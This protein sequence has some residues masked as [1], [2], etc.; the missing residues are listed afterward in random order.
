M[1]STS[2]RQFMREQVLIEAESSNRL[3]VYRA[4]LEQISRHPQQRLLDKAWVKEL[5][6]NMKEQGIDKA[7]HPVKVLLQDDESWD[8]QLSGSLAENGSC[9]LPPA[10][11]LL[12]FDGQHRLEACD[13]IAEEEGKW[14][15][16]I[17]FRRGE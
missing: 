13:S 11:R 8:H 14:W 15:Y 12:V 10:V 7:G 17:V 6:I 5:S 2:S 1:T 9:F 16:V 3:G 4:K